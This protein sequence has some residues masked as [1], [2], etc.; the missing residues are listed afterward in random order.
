MKVKNLP[1]TADERCTKCGTWLAHWK[2]HAGKTTSYCLGKGCT[3]SADVGA[4][5]K[6]VAVDDGKRYI[7]PLCYECNKKTE[8]FELK[9]NINLAPATPCKAQGNKADPVEKFIRSLATK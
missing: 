6:K 9:P 7:V 2:K 1:D 4:H 5:V 3:G 8:A